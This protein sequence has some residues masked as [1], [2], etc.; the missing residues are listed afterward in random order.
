[1]RQNEKN[2]HKN[3]QCKRALSRKF[4]KL[5]FPEYL[6]AFYNTSRSIGEHSSTPKAAVELDPTKRGPL[7]CVAGYAIA[8]QYQLNRR[9]MGEGNQEL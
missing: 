1:M 2:R 5:V 4:G 9:K 3:R 6:I 7:F 8:K